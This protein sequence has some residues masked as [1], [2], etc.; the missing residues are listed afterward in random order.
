MDLLTI[1]IAEL[2]SIS[3]RRI[4]QL[5]D[6]R[7]SG[8]PAFLAADAG[9]NSGMMLLPVR[10][11][12][13]RLGEQVAGPSGVGRLDP[14]QRQP[15]R[16]RLDGPDRRAPCARRRRQRRAG[17]GARAAVRGAGP[18][19]PAGRCRP[20]RAP[21]C[22]RPMHC[23]ASASGTWTPTANPAPTSTRRP[24]SFG[25]AS[26]GDLVAPASQAWHRDPD[27]RHR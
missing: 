8:L 19:L 2:G 26:L 24:R 21:A 11:R 6:A 4:A 20:R 18:R 25:R 9:L 3:E 10:R 23:S 17:P 7:T 16:P 22:R 15:G 27:H 5:V 1:A 14:D 13:A 12:R